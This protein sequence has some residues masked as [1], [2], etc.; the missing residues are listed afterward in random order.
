[1]NA[2]TESYTRLKGRWLL[3]ARLAWVAI[4]ILAT[5][6][7][8]AA[9]PVAFNLLR[10]P[11]NVEPCDTQ[12]QTA[13]DAPSAVQEQVSLRG[14][15]YHTILEAASRLVSL[16]VA[17]L[18]FWRRSAD[19]MALLTSIMLVTI[20]AI[21]SPSPLMLSA[22]QPLWHLPRALLWAIGLS[23][24]VGFLYL[25]PDGRFVPRWTRGLAIALL[26][27]TGILAAA[28]APFQSG[29]PVFV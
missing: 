27:G 4:A 11:C 20:F 26:V 12:F 24:A 3:S 29:L 8:A 14:A 25:F 28:G 15:W 2:Q 16:G 6:V 23:S 13:S 21:F 5:I 17:L 7:Y 10:T 19:W 18:I 22:A 1:M 9:A